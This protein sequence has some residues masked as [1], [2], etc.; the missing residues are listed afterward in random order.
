MFNIIGK[1]FIGFFIEV[2]AHV[3]LLFKVIGQVFSGKLHWVN[4]KKQLVHLGY[5]SLPITV[6]TAFFIGMVFAM[7]I[8]KEFMKYGAGQAVGGVIGVAFWR[9]LAP[10]LT[11]VII[12]GRAGAAI[13]AELGSM[14][15]TEQID[16]I[17]SF[18][19]DSNAYL[20]TPR[21]VAVSFILPLLVVIF[22]LVGLI[23]SYLMSVKIMTLN[24]MLFLDSINKMIKFKDLA[25]GLIKSLAFGAVISLIACRQGVSLKGGA[26]GVGVATTK[27]VVISLLAIFILNYFLSAVIF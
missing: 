13:T 8:T 9:E 24:S 23:G 14:K 19:V 5:D 4:L 3:L 16:A 6:I 15:V 1:S 22:D 18:A 27:T 11:A 2:G 7:Q 20:I 10:V 25:G 12:A 21:I 17:E 26:L